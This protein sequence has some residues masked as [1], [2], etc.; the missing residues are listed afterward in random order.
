MIFSKVI[1]FLALILISHTAL[2]YIPNLQ[3]DP[4]LI[5]Q[6]QVACNRLQNNLRATYGTAS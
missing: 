5:Y 4:L 2:I 3:V 6:T 1:T